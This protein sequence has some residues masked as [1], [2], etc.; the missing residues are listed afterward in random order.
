MVDGTIGESPYLVMAEV[1][2]CARVLCGVF[3]PSVYNSLLAIRGV[4]TAHNRG[5]DSIIKWGFW[6]I[7]VKVHSTLSEGFV[8]LTF[9]RIRHAYL[10]SAGVTYLSITYLCRCQCV[11]GFRHRAYHTP[12]HAASRLQP[13]VCCMCHVLSNEEKIVASL[14]TYMYTCFSRWGKFVACASAIHMYHRFLQHSSS[15]KTGI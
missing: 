7:F 14:R 13:A 8:T 2:E 3:V 5:R 1:L 11:P 15:A 9:G 12:R 4:A 10:V 6:T